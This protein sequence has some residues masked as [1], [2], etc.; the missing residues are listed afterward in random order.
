MPCDI[1]TFIGIKDH[2]SECS[3]QCA[4]N[5]KTTTKHKQNKRYTNAAMFS[6]NEH[7]LYYKIK[8]VFN[9]L[10]TSRVEKNKNIDND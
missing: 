4:Q 5:K 2:S 9:H 3:S 8:G 7:H 6:I 10:K 1:L